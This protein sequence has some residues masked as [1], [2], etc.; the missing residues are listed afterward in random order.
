MKT[1][2]SSQSVLFR[3]AADSSPA[4]MWVSDASGEI[5]FVN[6][7][8]AGFYG[9]ELADLLG[10][11]WRPFLHEADRELFV[12]LFRDALE[13]RVGLHQL[14]RV[15]ARGEPRWLRVDANPV[16]AE[17]GEFKG[18]VGVNIDVTAQVLAEQQ[19]EE[20]VAE[21]TRELEQANAALRQAQKM[22]AIGQLTGGIAH[23]FNNLLTVIRGSTD[24]LRRPDLPDAKRQR[25]VEAIAETADRAAKLTGQLLAFARRQTLK[26]EVFDAAERI[27]GVADML[28]SVLGS[29]IRL[30]LELD[31]GTCFVEADVAQFEAALVNLAVNARDAMD[32]EGRIAIRLS[33][34]DAGE[35]PSLVA[36]SVADSGCGIPSDDLER[37]FE[38]FFTT[39]EVGRGT[40]LGLSQVYGFAKQSDGEISVTSAAGEGATFTLSL[41]RA[42][43][44][45]IDEEQGD[46]EPA[47]RAHGCVLI[48]EDND[49]VRSFATQLLQ[50]VGYET[51][52]ASNADEALG[53]LEDAS[54]PVQLVFS[55]VVMPGMNGVELGREV[56]RRWPELRV[57]LTSGYSNTL[58]EEGRVDF[59]LVLKPYS[60]DQ[61][62]QSLEQA[63]GR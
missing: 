36:V 30:E 14:V 9:V 29:R 19:L 24:L 20:R 8:F 10:D 27:H 57:V 34:G 1:L 38:P 31:C 48:V 18:L 45:R 33:G 59:P 47:P 6:E 40:G 62:L 21:R 5:L 42:S 53:I 54:T 46:A 58:V 44:D 61:L 28:R 22:E 17:D 23:D 2:L 7:R 43:S 12:G 63:S 49:D 60:A 26:P 25:Y 35:E 51:C 55:D 3:T 16:F 56:R 37:I 4:M 32:G 52:V 41:P 50:D 39:K 13:R 15:V 11:G